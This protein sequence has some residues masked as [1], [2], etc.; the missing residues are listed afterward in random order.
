MVEESE[1]Y[2]SACVIC[3]RTDYTWGSLCGADGAKVGFL[4]DGTV[5]TT[6]STGEAVRVRQCGGCGNLQCFT[7]Q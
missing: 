4:P 2:D 3:G 6:G 7:E 1:T 5:L